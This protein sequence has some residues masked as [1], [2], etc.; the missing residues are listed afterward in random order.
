MEERVA[1]ELKET[2]KKLKVLE[3]K[4]KEMKKSDI[5]AY[6]SLIARV[7]E[8]RTQIDAARKQGWMQDDDIKEDFAYLGRA[9]GDVQAMRRELAALRTS[10]PRDLEDEIDQL[11]EVIMDMADDRARLAME[12]R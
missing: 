3:K 10:D 6:T 2:R 5:P 9:H 1:R 8:A 11:E 12:L 7:R 4:Q